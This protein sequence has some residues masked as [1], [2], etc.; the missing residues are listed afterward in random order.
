ML[1][2]IPTRNRIKEL[3]NTLNFLESNKFFFKKIV[4]VDSSNLE[5]KDQIKKKV[6]KYRANI[7]LVNSEPSTCIQRNVGFNFIKKSKYIMFLDDDNIFY[8]DAFYKMQNFLNNNKDFVGVAFNQIYKE[9]KN[10]LDNFKKNYITNKIGIYSLDNGGFSGSGWQSR[11]VN[12]ENNKIVQWLPTRA[13]IYRSSEIKNSRFDKKLGVYGYL[14]DLDF[15]LQLKKR[16]KLMVCS[17]AKY[18]HDQSITRP[19]FQFGK[20][21]L[22][23]RYYIVKKH[24]LNK[25][26]FFL[27]TFLR[28]LLTFKEGILGNLNS[29]KR[30]AGNLVALITINNLDENY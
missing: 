8:S 21:E 1:I 2:V 3:T 15:S 17:D 6:K 23:N 16:G 26:L 20:K 7:E 22:R 5:I 10:I 30:L 13:V 28:I 11:F 9:R 14:E 18:S 19:G 4:I 25:S 29:F 12:F 24:K 27:T